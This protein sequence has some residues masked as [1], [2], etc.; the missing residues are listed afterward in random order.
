[1]NNIFVHHVYF[2]LKHPDNAADKALL[3]Q[4]LQELST[5]PGIQSFHIGVPA[6][7]NRPVIDSSYSFSWLTTFAT[8]EDQDSYQTDPIHLAFVEKYSHLWSKV[9]VYDSVDA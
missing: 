2:W 1:M 5:V 3:H 4:G 7:T 8:A 6:G 9:I